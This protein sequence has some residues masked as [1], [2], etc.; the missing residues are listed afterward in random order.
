MKFPRHARIVRGQLDAAPF[1]AVFFLL[2]IF[3]MLGSLVYTPGARLQLQLPRADGLPGTDKP[4]VSVAVDADGRL[5]YENQWIEETKLQGRLREAAKK[6]PE[7]LT[8]VVQA[9]K[10]VSYETCLRL[11]LLARDAGISEALLATLPRAYATP[12]S[13][14]EP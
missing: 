13:R 11:A 9:D 8:L 3:M 12:G 6:C 10:S 4:T 7:P 14:S 1:A 5:Y 2:V